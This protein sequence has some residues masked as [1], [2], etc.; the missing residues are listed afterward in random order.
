MLSGFDKTPRL[1]AHTLDPLSTS[2]LL[3]ITNQLYPSQTLMVTLGMN[4]PVTGSGNSKTLEAVL[5]SFEAHDLI[6]SLA[7]TL[8]DVHKLSKLS[9]F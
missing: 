7:T 6:V 3:L 4:A 1:L 9:K 8:A 5:T 2:P